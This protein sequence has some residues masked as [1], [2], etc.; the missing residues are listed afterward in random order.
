MIHIVDEIGDRS[1]AVSLGCLLKDTHVICFGHRFVTTVPA[2][3]GARS[4]LLE[5]A[6]CAVDLIRIVSS[7]TW[8]NRD[9][10]SFISCVIFLFA[11]ITVV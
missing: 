4:Q 2:G 7:D 8:L 6:S 9:R 1:L 10:R 3:R 11:W 5:S